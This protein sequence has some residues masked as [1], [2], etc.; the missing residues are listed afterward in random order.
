MQKIEKKPQTTITKM[1]RTLNKVPRGMV[2]PKFGSLL[3][4][5]PEGDSPILDMPDMD[6]P[7]ANVDA[8]VSE[9]LQQIAAAKK[10]RR[11]AYRVMTDPNF[12]LVV[13]FQ[14]TDQRDE[15]VRQAK[16]QAV[17]A[18]VDGLDVARRLGLDV[19]PI[20]MPMKKNRAMPVALRGHKVLGAP[21]DMQPESEREEE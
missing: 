14:S 10:E 13:C 21:L 17:G 2:A 15:F 11:D 1:S 3:T 5:R 4:A 6:D 16:W 9:V 19:P 8:E 18:F 7:E 20:N 12:Y